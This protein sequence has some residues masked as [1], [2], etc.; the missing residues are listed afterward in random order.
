MMV[1]QTGG[2]YSEVVVDS[3][4]TVLLKKLYYHSPETGFKPS[5]LILVLQIHLNISLPAQESLPV[6]VGFAFDI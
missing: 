6:I 5:L 4:L 2:R 1:A 3:G